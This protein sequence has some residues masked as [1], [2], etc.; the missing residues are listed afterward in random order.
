MEKSLLHVAADAIGTTEPALR[1]LAVLFAG[2]PLSIIYNLCF[3]N[4]NPNL[5]VQLGK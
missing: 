3:V 2:I 1:L 5:K 4:F